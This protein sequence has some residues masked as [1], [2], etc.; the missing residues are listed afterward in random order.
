M[1]EKKKQKRRYL[2]SS[3][4]AAAEDDAVGYGS[5]QDRLATDLP[6]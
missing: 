3:S 5:D 2:T 1:Y 4:A 6:L